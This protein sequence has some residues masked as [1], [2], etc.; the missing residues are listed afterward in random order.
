MSSTSFPLENETGNGTQ[1]VFRY[2]RR[3]HHSRKQT[4]DLQLQLAEDYSRHKL[5]DV[6]LHISI[7]LHMA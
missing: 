5:S 7:E 1:N 2:Q 3:H 4:A 6:L